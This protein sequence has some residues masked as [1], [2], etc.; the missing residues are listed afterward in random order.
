MT[1]TAKIGKKQRR[2]VEGSYRQDWEREREGTG[3]CVIK[4]RH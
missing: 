4:D 3:R 1:E 2:G